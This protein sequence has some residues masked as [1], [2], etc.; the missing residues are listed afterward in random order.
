MKYIVQYT[1]PYEHL[2]QVGIEAESQEVAIA[3]AQAL[4]DQGDIWQDTTE[5]PLLYDDYV[6][7]SNVEV[8]LNFTIEG[9]CDSAWPTPDSSVIRMRQQNA[10]FR[11]SRLLVEAYQRGE[12]CGALGSIDW[13]DLDEAY[14][15]ALKS[16]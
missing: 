15:M 4:F 2:V 6:E 5:V 3:K 1:L 13:S 11:A 7:T 9:E 14:Q 16:I 12:A 10:A 8:P